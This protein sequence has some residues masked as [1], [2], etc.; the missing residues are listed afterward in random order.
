MPESQP[1]ERGSGILGHLLMLTYKE[2]KGHRGQG[3]LRKKGVCGTGRGGGKGNWSL[4]LMYGRRELD[5]IS[6]QAWATWCYT[7]KKHT[8]WVLKNNIQWGVGEMAQSLAPTVWWKV[9]VFLSSVW[10]CLHLQLVII[11]IH[12]ECFRVRQCHFN[13]R[14]S[15]STATVNSD[16][17]SGIVCTTCSVF[18]EFVK[19]FLFHRHSRCHRSEKQIIL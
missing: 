16:S 18:S 5:I 10:R 6:K 13:C 7:W 8:K 17:F 3:N 12:Y 11:V 19:L 4:H 2:I 14:L 9:A 1:M 15:S